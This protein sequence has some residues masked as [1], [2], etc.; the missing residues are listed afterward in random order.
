MI[1]V[2]CV[3]LALWS[4]ACAACTD[5]HEGQTASDPRRLRADF[6][7]DEERRSLGKSGLSKRSAAVNEQTCPALPGV[8]ATLQ[9]DTHS[10]SDRSGALSLF[11]SLQK[12]TR[13]KLRQKKRAS[14]CFFFGFFVFSLQ[15]SLHSVSAHG[16]ASCVHIV[17][18]AQNTH[19]N[20]PLELFYDINGLVIIV[21]QHCAQTR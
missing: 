16:A 2:R 12:S 11:V 1:L 20:Q 5:L 10:V 15:R 14:L 3:V 19:I 13:S 9:E 8:D 7:G 4:L 6:G 18:I 17:N 21:C